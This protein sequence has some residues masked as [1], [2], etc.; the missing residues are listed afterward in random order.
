MD[1]GDAGIGYSRGHRAAG[2][3]QSGLLPGLG[4][5]RA[6]SS[7]PGPTQAG[8][9]GCRERRGGALTAR[10]ELGHL[11]AEGKS[12]AEATGGAK[13]RQGSLGP[14]EPRHDCT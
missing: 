9:G 11:L 5:P 14:P 2:G 8:A 1:S 6:L 3:S 13:G 12:G 10:G 4:V 7:G